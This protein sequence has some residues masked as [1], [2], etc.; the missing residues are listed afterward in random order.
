M[1]RGS[2]FLLFNNI[3]CYGQENFTV[4]QDNN[5]N[6]SLLRLNILKGEKIIQKIEYLY[7]KE[8]FENA[9]Y[10]EEAFEIIDVNLSYNQKL[11]IGKNSLR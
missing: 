2:S 1:R 11:W 6:T 5:S 7:P 10:D 4:A 9:I 8:Y 3:L